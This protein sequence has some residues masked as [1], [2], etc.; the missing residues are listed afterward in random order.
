MSAG[1]LISVHH[2]GWPRKHR[3]RRFGG[4]QQRRRRRRCHRHRPSQAPAGARRLGSGCYS[5][6]WRPCGRE[7]AASPRCGEASGQRRLVY[8]YWSGMRW[9]WRWGRRWRLIFGIVE[10]GG[11]VRMVVACGWWWLRKKGETTLNRKIVRT[12]QGTEHLASAEENRGIQ[13]RADRAGRD[14]ISCGTA[15]RSSTR[16]W[17]PTSRAQCGQ[18][19][20]AACP[21]VER[22]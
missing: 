17:A 5:A 8:R 10:G 12:L 20:A 7:E 4:R 19:L 11:A 16:T 22:H 2:A 6:R 18:D 9:E 3:T 14:V 13:G 1:S 15:L 21:T